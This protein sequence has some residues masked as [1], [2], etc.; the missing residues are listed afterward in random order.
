MDPSAAVLAV[1]ASM[2]GMEVIKKL[3]MDKVFPP[4]SP[5]P[6]IFTKEEKKV[7]YQM[8]AKLDKIPEDILTLTEKEH[9]LLEELYTMHDARDQDGIPLWYV[10]RSWHQ[11]QQETL[12]VTKEI[13]FAQ[14]ETARALEGVTK[15]VERLADKIS[16]I[17][18]R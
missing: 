14:K 4:K 12:N 10:P 1:V 8:K 5:A 17:P 15:V 2:V 16:D 6:P 11:T 3:L 18:R 13:A 9:R 7:F